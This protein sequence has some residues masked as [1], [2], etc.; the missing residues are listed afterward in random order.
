[1]GRAAHAAALAAARHRALAALP[2]RPADDAHTHHPWQRRP[3]H[4]ART[5]AGIP[6]RPSRARR[7]ERAGGLSAR[8]ARPARARTR[9]RRVAAHDRV[10]RSLS[11]N[12]V[13][14]QS[15]GIASTKS[16]R[17]KSPN[18]PILQPSSRRKPGSTPP[19]LVARLREYPALRGAAPWIPAFA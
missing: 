10:F 18:A 3:L 14:R 1:R 4:A 2:P 9:P 11:A 16:Y 5:G 17:R 15:H 6:C 7:D 8:G 19:L 13:A 12:G